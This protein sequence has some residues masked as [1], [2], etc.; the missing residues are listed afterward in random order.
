MPFVAP[1]AKT[2]F[3]IDATKYA[4]MSPTGSG[5]VHHTGDGREGGSMTPFTWTILEGGKKADVKATTG[6]L[7]NKVKDAILKNLFVVSGDAPDRPD[8]IGK[9]WRNESGVHLK[10]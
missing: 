6:K 5:E 10:K 8:S 1:T 9:R 4:I 2:R 7:P 3:R